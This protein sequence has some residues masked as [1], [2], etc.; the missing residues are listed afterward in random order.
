[1]DQVSQPTLS[2]SCVQPKVT[3]SEEEKKARLTK[4]QE[5]WVFDKAK[6]KPDYPLE[7]PTLVTAEPWHVAAR[8]YDSMRKRSVFTRYEGSQAHCKTST[9][10]IYTIDLYESGDGGTLVEIIRQSG[11]A[12]AFRREREAVINAAEALGSSAPSRLPLPL[13][14]PENLLQQYEAPPKQEHEN[15]LMRASDLFHSKRDVQLFALQNLASI[16][17]TDKV[18]QESAQVMS[19]LIMQNCSDVR[20]SIAHIMNACYEVHDGYSCQ[21][22]NSCLTVFSNVFTVLKNVAMIETVLDENCDERFYEEILKILANIVGDCKCPHNATL[23]LRCICSL[24]EH[25]AIARENVAPDIVRLVQSA[26]E[27]GK[28]K[29]SDLENMA[30]AALEVLKV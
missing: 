1:M 24:L 7:R 3:K 6:T 19:E 18:N 27:F 30:G 15:T 16:T 8:I 13:K 20:D 5:K 11:C 25:S 12:F 21:I 10:L 14:I 29:H 17:S 22:Q 28:A 23:S 4:W 26:Q 2:T 9:F